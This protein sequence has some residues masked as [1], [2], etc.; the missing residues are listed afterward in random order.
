MGQRSDSI[1]RDEHG[2]PRVILDLDISALS[3]VDL[4]RICGVLQ[5]RLNALASLVAKKQ[6]SAYHISMPAAIQTEFEQLWQA[7][8][9]EFDEADDISPIFDLIEF[10]EELDC[11]TH[12]K[13]QSAGESIAETLKQHAPFGYFYVTNKAVQSAAANLISFEYFL[14]SEFSLLPKADSIQSGN[15]TAHPH[16]FEYSND[17]Y[18]PTDVAR[19]GED[20]SNN[21]QLDGGSQ[22]T[23]TKKP[24]PDGNDGTEATTPEKAQP[25]QSQPPRSENGRHPRATR[26]S[27]AEK[28]NHANPST[29]PSAP[30]VVDGTISYNFMTGEELRLQE[31]TQSAQGNDAQHPAAD[32]PELTESHRLD[33]A[34]LSG[35][36]VTG[37]SLTQFVER[38]KPHTW[39]GDIDHN[40]P[41]T[42]N[43]E[44]ADHATT[45]SDR[46]DSVDGTNQ[47]DAA[48][49]PLLDVSLL[50]NPTV[51][52]PLDIVIGQEPDGSG[53]G[54]LSI[55]H[56]SPNDNTLYG[57][58]GDDILY[59]GA[60]SDILYGG[61]GDDILYGGAGDDI[62]YGGAG[63]DILIGEAGDDTLYGGAGDDTL[64]G[65][66]GDDTLYGGA[67]SDILYGGAGDD[68]LI[69]EAGND[70]IDGGTG[71]DEIYGGNGNDRLLGAGG[72]GYDNDILNGGSGD[73]TL[74][75]GDDQGNNVLEGGSGTDIL[76]SFYGDDVL[77]GGD[78]DDVLIGFSAFGNDTLYGGAGDDILRGGAGDDIL[79]GGSGDDT[80]FGDGTIG[81][82]F[83]GNDTLDGGDGDDVLIGGDG[84]DVLIG[85]SGD[86]VL[87]GGSGD[88]V[89]I[90]GSDNDDLR[91]GSGDDTLFGGDDV[92]IG[93]RFYGNDTLDGG[94][95]DDVLIGG[96]GDDDLRG[97]SGDDVLIGGAGD[98]VLIGGS[99]DDDLR[100]G[101][102]DDTLFGGNPYWTWWHRNIRDT[103]DGGD[104]N[105][106]LRGDS[107]D[108][109]LG[110]S[111]DD[112][113][114]GLM[115][116][117]E[118]MAIMNRTRN[119]SD[120][121][122]GG[123]GDDVL[124]GGNGDD[125]LIGGDGDDVLIGGAGNDTLI[126][127]SGADSFEL[128]K[129]QVLDVVS[130]FQIG[131][132]KIQLKGI[133]SSSITVS[134]G[135]GSHTSDTWVKADGE[136]VLA[137]ENTDAS[138]ITQSSFLEDPLI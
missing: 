120:T 28:C 32:Q 13:S 17:A 113:L 11:L 79:R 89:L 53:Y 2:A 22:A 123:D 122:D 84:D 76:F 68:I 133:S 38:V 94:D 5:A 14:N 12:Q 127:G 49:L 74:F 26:Q 27:N 62:L 126:G 66:A 73:D 77:I 124:I 45:R 34:D 65:G 48:N 99:G 86:D 102:G 10:C 36:P 107:C 117:S 3:A 69:G 114:S 29:H 128:R 118:L 78:G 85:G 35:Q 30:S 98:D 82:R 132:D 135:I 50:D 96:S 101:S 103:L 91:G 9:G 105:D 111:G 15:A 42:V 33:Q 39:Q 88:D 44:V 24:C 4:D 37:S 90:G 60:G 134:Q 56:G 58:A 115:A 83:Y 47:R 20:G 93:F 64:Y 70:T 72:I 19:Q 106:Y 109:V 95:G 138:L 46:K 119:I 54:D 16:W 57:G 87:R 7:S 129:N 51:D 61:A 137:L 131:V 43:H 125:V 63:D 108:D 75:G 71:S 31:L 55:Q 40:S 6:T 1:D 100:G 8:Q 21:D 97:G 110:G 67:G 41:Q 81:F 121:L 23:P 92:L 130:D 52:D 59:G 104:G 80:L 18:L 25:A 136:L 116:I 112:T